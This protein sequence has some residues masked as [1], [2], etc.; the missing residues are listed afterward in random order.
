MAQFSYRARNKEGKLVKGT[1][2]APNEDRAST[3]L[4]Q[5]QLTPV[6]ISP[7]SRTSIFDR[8]IFGSSV[9]K[10]DLIV[11]NRQT[12]SMIN[13]GVPIL[14]ALKAIKR[15]A[16]KK[17]TKTVL[18]E[19]IYDVEGGE[20]LSNSMAKH[21]KV[22]SPFF[23]GVI[24]TGEASG[25]LSQSLESLADHIEQD[26]IFTRKVRSALV[27][28]VFVLGVVIILSIVMFVFVLPQLTTLFQ[29]AGVALPLPTRILIGTIT[30]FQNYWIIVVLAFIAIGLVAR[31]YLRT[32]EGRYTLSTVV[33]QIPVLKELF[34]KV[35]LARITSILQTLFESDVPILE[36]LQLAKQAVGNRVYQ[37]I[38]NDTANAVKDGATISS[39]WEHEPFIAPL[40]TTMVG[41]G[42]RSGEISE[43]FEQA[44]QFFKRDVDSML[45]SITILL[46]PILI[47]VLAIGVAIVVAA[48]LLP[49]Y[50]LVLVL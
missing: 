47:I 8:E 24:R 15:Q 39:V 17:K 31:S 9:S 1:L 30:F 3:L 48:V 20:S 22:F 2:R 10:K 13:A 50:N 6:E 4:R 28:P 14:E 25:R 21:P 42:E 46:E 43:S 19:M 27:Y 41:V 11:L 5:N 12:S 49:I 18:Q 29:D 44:N 23:L 16:E 35:Y 37:R 32:A 34:Q 36:S 40:L 33:L 45:D 7:G 26:Y 38:L